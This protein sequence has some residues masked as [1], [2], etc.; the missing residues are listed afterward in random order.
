MA[1]FSIG[2]FC[3]TTKVQRRTGGFVF[4]ENRFEPGL[5]IPEHEHL[6]PHFTQVLEGGFEERY[7]STTLC[8]DLSATLVVP[9]RQSHS[10]R[11]GTNG[12][13]T[14]SVEPLPETIARLRLDVPVLAGPALVGGAASLAA[15]RLHRLFS[16][17]EGAC[18]ILLEA[19]AL[20]VLSLLARAEPK[21]VAW[22]EAVASYL[23]AHQNASLEEVA[24]ECTVH[25]AHLA[26]S[27]RARFGE[28][29]GRYQ[30]RRRLER[31]S[32]LL[33]ETNESVAGVAAL[34]G[35][36]DHAHLSR[37]FRAEYGTSPGA[38]RSHAKNVQGLLGG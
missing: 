38:F 31:A 21:R 5:Y 35:F 23:D 17:G 34:C 16:Q 29:V 19:R 3:G 20:E 15:H 8:A 14:F 36:S 7:A 9:E 37:L 18:P 12:A 32:Q 10:D 1:T 11:M 28:S 22:I 2:S 25:P 13:R 33:R 6:I 26:R 4:T 30:R 27:F 24:R